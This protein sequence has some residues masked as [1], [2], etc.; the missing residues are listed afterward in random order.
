VGRPRCVR[1]A[2]VCDV[3]VIASSV[4]VH[5]TATDRRLGNFN[6]YPSFQALYDTLK[7]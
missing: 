3:H 2:G 6:H 4:G 5:A 1:G 7:Y